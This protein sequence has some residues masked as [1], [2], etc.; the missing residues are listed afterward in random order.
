MSS[1]WNK[2][3]DAADEARLLFDAG[4]NDGACSRAYYAM[5]NAA[6]ALLITKGVEPD[7][8]KTH[9]SVHR[10]FSLIFVQDSTF[11]ERAGRA[12]RRAAESRSIADYDDLGLQHERTKAVMES[13]EEF[14]LTA[15]RVMN[16][17][18]GRSR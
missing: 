5:F 16:D 7:K 3:R 10:L 15:E 11:A 12:L 2:A 14:M 8:V 9:R 4:L 17:A 6:R 18:K 13:M 1:L